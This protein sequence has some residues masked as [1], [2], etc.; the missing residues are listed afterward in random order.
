MDVVTTILLGAIGSLIASEIYAHG[1]LIAEWIISHAVLRLPEDQQSRFR[2]EWHADNRDFAG[3]IRKVAHA[4]GCILGAP[5]VAKALAKP[6]RDAVA[7]PA[8]SS[9]AG[10][11]QIQGEKSEVPSTFAERYRQRQLELI[12]K[13]EPKFDEW[14]DKFLDR[15]RRRFLQ[16]FLGECLERRGASLDQTNFDKLYFDLS[17]MIRTIFE[18]EDKHT[19]ED[20]LRN[21]LGKMLTRLVKND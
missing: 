11:R 17:P 5:S 6:R 14:Q 2:E 15:S 21:L 7:P 9:A 13:W 10:H 3:S 19:A 1:S 8:K 12:E 18:N 20:E 4:V 16:K